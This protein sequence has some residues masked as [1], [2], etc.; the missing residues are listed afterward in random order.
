MFKG[1]KFCHVKIPLKV[2]ISLNSLRACL[3]HKYYDRSVHYQ[4]NPL[5]STTIPLQYSST[6]TSLT[7]TKFREIRCGRSSIYTPDLGTFGF[8]AWLVCCQNYCKSLHDSICSCAISLS[9]CSNL[10]WVGQ[11]RRCD[12]TNAGCWMGTSTYS[13]TRV[14]GADWGCGPGQ[15]SPSPAPYNDA[16]DPRGLLLV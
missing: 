7:Q 3:V 16:C 6:Q 8:G 1:R 11:R 4:L 15:W 13:T 2:L 9:P 5:H 12:D 14:T 10:V